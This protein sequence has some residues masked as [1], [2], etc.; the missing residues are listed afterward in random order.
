M[1]VQWTDDLATGIE[2]ID[3]QHRELYQRV[4]GLHEAMRGGRLDEVPAMVDY[5]QRYAVEHFAA[6]EKQMAAAGYPGLGQ[7]R[8]LHQ[9]FVEEFL[10]HR[11]RLSPQ[12]TASAVVALSRWIT[13]WLGD[14]VRKVD[15]EMARYLR[16]QGAD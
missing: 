11:K 1:P 8:R 2:R 5:L 16:R 6:E 12:V 14:H 3:E 13:A 9:R 15:G 4:A 10:E 7:H